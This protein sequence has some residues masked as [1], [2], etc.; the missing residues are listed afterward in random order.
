MS[1][2]H[3]P[4]WN[5]EDS[6]AFA[7]AVAIAGKPWLRMRSVDPDRRSD[8][9]RASAAFD[10]DTDRPIDRAVL[11]ATSDTGY[12]GRRKWSESPATIKPASPGTHRDVVVSAPLPDGTRA[13]F[14]N[15]ESG[16]LTASSELVEIG[17]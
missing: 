12:T 16:P 8:P 4:G 9:R 11:I 2:G 7:T 6:Y 14:L 15:V 1:H 5:A 17:P 10:L 13:W 3:G